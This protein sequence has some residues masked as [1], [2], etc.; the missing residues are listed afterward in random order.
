MDTQR[1]T[2]PHHLMPFPQAPIG[3]K[4]RPSQYTWHSWPRLSPVML[5]A[6][7]HKSGVAPIIAEKPKTHRKSPRK[8]QKNPINQTIQEII[9]GESPYPNRNSPKKTQKATKHCTCWQGVSH[10][11][12]LKPCGAVL[13][14]TT[15][16]AALKAF[17]L[18]TTGRVLENTVHPQT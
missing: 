16:M 5:Q 15:A 11:W 8:Y 14:H 7:F 3:C 6:E 18:L 17:L 9:L 13:A 2:V 10:C 12:P 1:V 4:G